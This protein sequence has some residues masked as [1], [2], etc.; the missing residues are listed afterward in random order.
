MDWGR[1]LFNI[2][3]LIGTFIAGYYIGALKVL[4]EYAEQAN[5]IQNKLVDLIEDL[6]KR[7]AKRNEET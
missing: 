2:G 6:Y 5:K 7:L 3:A 4:R 1:A